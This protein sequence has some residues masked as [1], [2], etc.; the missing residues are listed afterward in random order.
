MPVL[1]NG[2]QLEPPLVRIMDEE[3]LTYQLREAR[4]RYVTGCAGHGHRRGVR[5]HILSYSLYIAC[6]GHRYRILIRVLNAFKV[7][8][9]QFCDYRLI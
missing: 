6:V 1:V 8:C 2:H 7:A 9:L 5:Y 3:V 4:H